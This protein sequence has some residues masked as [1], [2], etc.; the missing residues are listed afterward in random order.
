MFLWES[1]GSEKMKGS[2]SD[3]EGK[4]RKGSLR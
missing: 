3:E 1:E 2:N 4:E